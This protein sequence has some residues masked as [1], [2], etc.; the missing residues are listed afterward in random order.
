MANV[1]E[2]VKAQEVRSKSDIE[3]LYNTTIFNMYM[4]LN[5]KV[6]LNNLFKKLLTEQ[7]ELKTIVV[8]YRYRLG[9]KYEDN[10]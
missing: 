2:L 10:K 6:G 3:A 1:I 7:E 9:D 8:N 4:F 5:N